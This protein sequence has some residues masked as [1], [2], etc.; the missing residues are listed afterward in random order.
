MK[1]EPK[2]NMTL[3]SEEFMAVRDLATAYKNLPPVVDDDYPMLRDGYEGSMHRLVE[4]LYANGRLAR[5]FRKPVEAPSTGGVSVLPA[6]VPKF[7]PGV[8][9][10]FRVDNS[11]QER[12]GKIARVQVRWAEG[13]EP[14]A[15][16]YMRSRISRVP[17]THVVGVSTLEPKCVEGDWIAFRAFHHVPVIGQVIGSFVD[18][19]DTGQPVIMHDVRQYVDNKPGNLF[20]IHEGAVINVLGNAKDED[21]G[22]D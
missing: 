22:E 5:Y 18:K 15:F 3:Q 16:Y 7:S 10:S 2:D 6:V 9:V 4:A 11:K 19:G 12:L 20:S 21:N 17:E 13:E 1:I 8:W 14:T